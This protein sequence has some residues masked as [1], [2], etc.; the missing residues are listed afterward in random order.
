VGGK[1]A[2]RVPLVPDVSVQDVDGYRVTLDT[3]GP[4]AALRKSQLSFS[5][6]RDG[7]PVRDLEPLHGAPGQLVVVSEDRK[8]FLP[9]R[10]IAASAGATGPDVS[11]ACRFPVA[12]IYKAWGRFQRQGRV[13]TAAFT[14]RVLPADVTSAAEPTGSPDE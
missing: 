5:L 11:F 10:A 8:R 6:A 12:G 3:G 14:L 7:V 13:M 9:T 2:A 1:P 4:L